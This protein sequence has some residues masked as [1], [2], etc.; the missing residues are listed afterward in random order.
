MEHN[1]QQ[2]IV[3]WIFSG[4]CGIA[5][6]MLGAIYSELKGIRENLTRIAVDSG[7]HKIRI[8]ALERLNER[9]PCLLPNGK[10]T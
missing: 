4:V 5:L 2:D 6:V 10:C 3:L 7:E 8:I 1:M 9:L